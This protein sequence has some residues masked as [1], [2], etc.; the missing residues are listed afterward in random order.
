M[1]AMSMGHHPNL[2][3]LYGSILLFD[4]AGGGFRDWSSWI[5]GVLPSQSANAFGSAGIGG[6]ITARVVHGCA[7]GAA[8]DGEEVLAIAC[9]ACSTPGLTGKSSGFCPLF[10][11]GDSSLLVL[12]LASICAISRVATPC[13][14]SW[15]IPDNVGSF[16]NICTTSSVSAGPSWGTKS[17][18]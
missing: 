8:F 16:N 10:F 18:R 7:G 15:E 2:Q 11:A 6:P 12:I 3:Q 14:W 1:L 13:A 5:A 17:F 9:L 4:F